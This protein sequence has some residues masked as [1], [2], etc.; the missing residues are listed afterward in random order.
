MPP[1]QPTIVKH[2]VRESGVTVIDVTG[3][4]GAQYEMRIALIVPVVF[5]TGMR[6]PLDDTPIFNIQANTAVQIV[7]K[8]VA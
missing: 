7:R 2:A 4:D 6:N 8:P 1:A 5:D 3:S